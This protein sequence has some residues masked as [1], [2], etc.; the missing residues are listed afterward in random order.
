[1]NADKIF[2]RLIWIAK[3]VD[4]TIKDFI[5]LLLLLKHYLFSMCG[6]VLI[7]SGFIMSTYDDFAAHCVLLIV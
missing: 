6:S 2:K 3:C 4:E 7:E 5:Y 1:M